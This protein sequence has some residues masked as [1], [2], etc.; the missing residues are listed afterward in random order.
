M[1]LQQ[2]SGNSVSQSQDELW[3]KETQNKTLLARVALPQTSAKYGYRAIKMRGVF[4][5]WSGNRQKAGFLKL[6]LPSTQSQLAS[7]LQSSKSYFVIYTFSSTGVMPNPV[8]CDY[9]DV[10]VIPQSPLNTPYVTKICSPPDDL[11]FPFSASTLFDAGAAVRKSLRDNPVPGNEA[12]LR[13]PKCCHGT[14]AVSRYFVGLDS[15]DQV[16]RTV[17]LENVRITECGCGL[18]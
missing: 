2:S 9:Y 15:Q 13:N 1:N 18:G 7:N 5:S 11:T 6:T 14:E 17:K 4:A 10:T 8:N 3:V 16:L 12:V